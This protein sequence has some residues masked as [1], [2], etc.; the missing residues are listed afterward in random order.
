MFVAKLLSFSQHGLEG[1]K[2]GVKLSIIQSCTQYLITRRGR[3]HKNI[4]SDW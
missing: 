3:N 2:R 1:D 4:Q